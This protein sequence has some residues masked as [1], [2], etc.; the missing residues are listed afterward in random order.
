MV[1]NSSISP[2]LFKEYIV[3]EEYIPFCHFNGNLEA[4]GNALA[5]LNHSVV[6]QLEI[7]D[8][9][10]CNYLFLVD[11]QLRKIIHCVEFDD[12]GAGYSQEITPYFSIIDFDDYGARWEGECANDMPCGWGCC[13][14]ADGNLE[15]EGFRFGE[16]N[17]CYGCYF[18]PD[19][20]SVKYIGTIHNGNRVGKGVSYGRNG[21]ELY[22]GYWL[23]DV[24]LQYEQDGS[25]H[26]FSTFACLHPSDSCLLN[27]SLLVELKRLIISSCSCRHVRS[28]SIVNAPKLEILK[29]ES[30]SFTSLLEEYSLPFEECSL[31]VSACPLLREVTIEDQC[32]RGTRKCV[33][34]STPLNRMA[35]R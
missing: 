7:K 24:P 34:S 9:M 16:K 14:D 23:D 17:V 19:L 5:I 2:F 3:S 22:S 6:E 31:I 30:F 1:P 8:G 10:L 35:F 32:F 18:Y 25:I 20:H 13:Y 11:Y 4:V 27:I 33:V 29:I 12:E 26:S 21:E 15:Y 28:L